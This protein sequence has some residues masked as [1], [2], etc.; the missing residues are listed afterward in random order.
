MS[1]KWIWGFEVGADNSYYEGSDWSQVSPIPAGAPVSPFYGEGLTQNLENCIDYK[2]NLPHQ[3]PGKAGGGQY[4][5]RVENGIY[6]DGPYAAGDTYSGL[7]VGVLSPSLSLGT[8]SSISLSLHSDIDFTEWPNYPGTTPFYIQKFLSIYPN[9][10]QMTQTTGSDVTIIFNDS[11]LSSS[12]SM[13]PDLPAQLQ[14]YVYNSGSTGGTPN[15]KI[16]AVCRTGFTSTGS[17]PTHATLGGPC[18]SIGDQSTV[19]WNNLAD[20]KVFSSLSYVQDSSVFPNPNFG[21]VGYTSSNGVNFEAGW[22]EIT[23]TYS[24]HPT[25]GVIKIHLNGSPI[26]NV[27][28]AP[29]GYTASVNEFGDPVQTDLN[30]VGRIMFSSTPFYIRPSGK[31]EMLT[32]TIQPANYN[33]D[34]VVAFDSLSDITVATSSIYVQGI[35]PTTDSDIGSFIGDDSSVVEL[36][37][38]IDDPN[39]FMNNNYLKAS[40]SNSSCNFFTKQLQNITAGSTIW[41]MSDV[42][43]VVGVNVINSVSA[44]LDST[45]T[46][47]SVYRGCDP[48]CSSF[49]TGSEFSLGGKKFVFHVSGSDPDG[50]SWNYLTGSGAEILISGFNFTS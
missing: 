4:S 32:G 8:G 2:N 45:L 20:P 29:T 50:R 30:N 40:G 11:F 35:E 42:S 1:I 47:S 21:L 43:E 5:L 16:A 25:N 46:G 27:E 10:A 49:A 19:L 31:G 14:L 34:H 9:D 17:V 13:V 36:W 33:F 24:P 41:D 6:T 3:P 26:I 18:L 48:G 37:N 44:S 39:Y 15:R 12:L 23:V 28:G 7:S 22:N 38:Y